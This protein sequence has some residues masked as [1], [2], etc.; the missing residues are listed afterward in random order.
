MFTRRSKA[1][2]GSSRRR[3]AIPPAPAELPQILALLRAPRATRGSYIME[4]IAAGEADGCSEVVRAFALAAAEEFQLSV[5]LLD[6]NWP[7]NPQLRAL[8]EIAEVESWEL[9][10]T[11][12]V[13]GGASGPNPLVSAQIAFHQ[14]G[15]TKLVVSEAKSAL[16]RHIYYPGSGSDFWKALRGVVDLVIIDAPPASASLDGVMVAPE[17]DSVILVV[18][19]EETRISDA[20]ELRD[21]ICLQGGRPA[22]IVFNKDRQ[23]L[24]RFLRGAA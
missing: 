2:Q 19:A 21:R 5:M 4:F 12:A 13:L 20:E 22:G 11:S 17:A 7:A 16:A 1:D 23:R 10:E 15:G 3:G 14:V 8:S 6:L 24:P 9:F 18:A